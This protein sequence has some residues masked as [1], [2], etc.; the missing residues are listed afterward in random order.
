MT[1]DWPVAQRPSLV[2][3]EIINRKDAVVQS[4]DRH[5]P[6]TNQGKPPGALWKISN[7]SNRHEITHRVRH[8]TCGGVFGSRRYFRAPGV[9][10]VS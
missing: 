7:V 5:V 3:A 8:L 2:Q 10:V 1:L 6:A 9:S 4:E